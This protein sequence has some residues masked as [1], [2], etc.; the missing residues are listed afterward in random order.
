MLK[1]IIV[2]LLL[3]THFSL[4]P[5]APAPAGKA[6]FYWPFAADSKPWFAFIGGLPQQSG[7]FVTPLLA[8]LAG[9]GFLVAALSLLGWLIPAGWWMPSVV[10]ACAASLLLY[11]LY[12]GMWAIL[13]LAVDGVLLWGVLFQ[14]WNVA[15]LRGM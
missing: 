3:A 15:G 9:F 5:F 13:P 12:F 14:H 8:G 11:V 4:T 1:T 2:L 6:T 10:I 7:G